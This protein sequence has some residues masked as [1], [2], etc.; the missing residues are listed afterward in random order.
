MPEKADNVIIK[1]LDKLDKN[2]KKEIDS[3]AIN[4]KGGNA[5]TLR[6]K[7]IAVTEDNAAKINLSGEKIP[8][9]NKR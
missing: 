1:N 2:R 3:E 6:T 4:E 8:E 9:T 5:K 7:N